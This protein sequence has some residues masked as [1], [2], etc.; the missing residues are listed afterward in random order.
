MQITSVFNI[1]RS[2]LK[3]NIYLL[4][5]NKYYDAIGAVS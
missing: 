5:N 4:N 1:E 3:Y 2:E